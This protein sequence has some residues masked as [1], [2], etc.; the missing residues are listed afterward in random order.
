VEAPSAHE[1]VE[2][3]FKTLLQE[4]VFDEGQDEGQDDT[5]SSSEV[6]ELSVWGHCE[7]IESQHPAIEQAEILLYTF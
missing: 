6:T 1:E 7:E 2:E 4:S 3:K 5:M